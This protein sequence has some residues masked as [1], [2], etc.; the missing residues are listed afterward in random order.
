MDR[1]RARRDASAP[2]MSDYAQVLRCYVSDDCEVESLLGSVPTVVTIISTL[3]T[4]LIAVLTQLTSAARLR[5]KVAFWTE[6]ASQRPSSYDE[7]IAASLRRVAL[8]K[9]VAL[10][11]RPGWAVAGLFPGILLGLAYAAMA[12]VILYQPIPS[13]FNSGDI[14]HEDLW[15]L[16][17]G[18]IVI[19]LM[20]VNVL[21]K[22]LLSRR[23]IVHQYLNG[24]TLGVSDQ[25]RNK[26]KSVGH[27]LSVAF[28][29]KQSYKWVAW[30]LWPSVCLLTG[31]I[32]YRLAAG[33]PYPSPGPTSTLI[34]LAVLGIV[35]GY[36]EAIRV[37]RAADANWH[38]PRLV[39][40]E[41]A[42]QLRHHRWPFW[43]KG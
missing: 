6:H 23:R 17:G 38:H 26:P 37:L 18:S 27:F 33:L 2:V 36:L 30:F 34:V 4:V 15:A 39:A 14:G 7:R 43:S 8:A 42:Q 22:V 25:A 29:W 10:D 12:G 9:L 24:E 11:A 32:A 40:E 20:S 5:R 21:M 13:P 19:G 31:C 28:G 3:V 1:A 35:N 16:I 41:E